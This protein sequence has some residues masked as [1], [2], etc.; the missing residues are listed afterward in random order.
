MDTPEDDA[1]KNRKVTKRASPGGLLTLV[2]KALRRQR[3]KKRLTQVG[4]SEEAGLSPNVV[5]RI[6]RG[7]YN[8]SL[9]VLEDIA[10][11]LDIRVFALFLNTDLLDIWLGLQHE[12][13]FP[14]GWITELR[15]RRV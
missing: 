5:G 1:K 6:E 10:T 13:N 14:S 8:P 3:R 7:V 15:W 12:E 2:G 11:V 9:R 4:L